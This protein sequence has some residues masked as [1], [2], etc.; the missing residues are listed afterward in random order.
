[1]VKRLLSLIVA[2]IAAVALT[3]G[4][5]APANANS[6]Y[7]SK[8][9]YSGSTY[10]W[11]YAYIDDKANS[12]G[13]GSFNSWSKITNTTKQ[14]TWIRDVANFRSYGLGSISVGSTVS[15]TISGSD[16]SISWTNSN[17]AT[18]SYL[19]GTVCAS[20]LIVYVGMQSV[21][22]GFYNGTTRI[23]STGWL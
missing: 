5:I 23:S 18:G 21:G 6:Q 13:C 8:V 7:S 4:S 16:V 11:S 10:L 19:S 15:G 2:C 20:W 12:N 14:V 3:I 9:Y 17:G 22:T 1:M